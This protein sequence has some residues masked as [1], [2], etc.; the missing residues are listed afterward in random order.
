M[1]YAI[2]V[3]GLGEITVPDD[4]S[5][6]DVLSNVLVNKYLSG[7]MSDNDA[8]LSMIEGL[9][10]QSMNARRQRGLPPP[11]PAAPDRGYLGEA[12]AG[13]WAGMK[14]TVG[15]GLSGIE[16]LAERW[17]LDPTGDEAG[18]LRQAGESLK[19]GADEIKASPDLP[20]WYFKTFNAFGSILGFAGAAGAAGVASI[21]AGPASGLAALGITGAFAGG[22]GADEAYE[23]AI[24]GKATE[25]QID[26][27]TTLGF[28]IGLTELIAPLR[29]IR[30]LKKIMGME[31]AVPNRGLTATSTEEIRKRT[32]DGASADTL[33]KNIGVDPT[34]F[35]S[36]GKR[37]A[38]TAGLEGSQEAVAAIAQNAVEKYLYNP[39][40]PLVD[41]QAFEEGLYG[42]G[43]GAM[44]EGILGIYGVRKSRG[45][46][47]KVDEFM[48]SDQYNKINKAADDSIRT[49]DD[50]EATPEA[51][52][53]AE[54]TL[55]RA[56]VMM[57]TALRDN[58]FNSREVVD[59]LKDQKDENGK[60]VYTEEYL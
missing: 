38:A 51:K 33:A 59:Y 8:Q 46:R 36:F 27:A 56:D 37:V 25:Q 41:S 16:R 39:D 43:A 12:G 1:P 47:K 7:Q 26:E 14:Y 54:G 21:V 44:L 19:K 45:F 48:D 53:A 30:G 35:R 18:W 49:M 2:D 11:E 50:P 5:D 57:E 10:E 42:G 23:R 60:P 58:V 32:I 31:K 24:K 15:S 17:N 20:E 40:T 4:A 55:R 52:A 34:P 29:A 13:L 22:T 6:V 9:M 3:D 28:G